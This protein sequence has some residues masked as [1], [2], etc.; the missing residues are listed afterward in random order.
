MAVTLEPIVWIVRGG[1]G[2]RKFGD[3]FEASLTAIK[4]DEATVRLA[5][6]S[7]RISIAM[8]RASDAAF[9]AIGLTVRKRTRHKAR[10]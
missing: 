9:D 8:Y 6:L 1:P 10:K 4:I 3:P 7:G 2:H 5:G